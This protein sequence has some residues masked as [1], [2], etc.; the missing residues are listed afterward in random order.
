[1]D[2]VKN[3][4]NK[5]FLIMDFFV[6]FMLLRL[7]KNH[8]KHASIRSMEYTKNIDFIYYNNQLYTNDHTWH[9][10]NNKIIQIKSDFFF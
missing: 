10:T 9:G 1:M 8:E 6:F 2:Y 5:N 4:W 7:V 3:N